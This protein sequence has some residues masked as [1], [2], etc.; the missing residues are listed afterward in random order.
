MERL[1]PERYAEIAGKM[2]ELL[3]RFYCRAVLPRQY[4]NKPSYGDV[5]VLVSGSISE[6]DP[7][8]ELGSAAVSRNGP[9]LSFEYEGHQVDVIH[10]RAEVF[11]L[12]LFFYSW[13]D[14][15]MV[16][17]MMLRK[18]GLKFGSDGLF[19]LVEDTKLL[20]SS[21][22]S[23]VLA[24]LGMDFGR[25]QLGFSTRE[26]IF[27]FI[28][29]GRFFR[30]SM[31]KPRT[32]SDSAGKTAKRFKLRPMFG[33]F[34]EYVNSRLPAQATERV[35]AEDVT[36]LAIAYFGQEA[37]VAH[38]QEQAQQ[39]RLVKLKF[40]GDIV[41]RLTGLSGRPLGVLMATVRGQ[42]SREQLLSWSA[43]QLEVEVMKVYR[44][45]EREAG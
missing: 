31:F 10:C 40:N 29:A 33:E 45:D 21:D 3:Q 17:G 22:V 34:V 19:V 1:T 44:A 30:H 9:V 39:Q 43:E 26:E 42:V 14:V 15:G 28:M 25:W 16:L 32:S 23:S 5:D 4:P 41:A 18:L 12:A 27:E 11:D 7:A 37:Q 35:S 20:L 38:V 6:F 24:F 36:Q 8:C 2:V 13:G